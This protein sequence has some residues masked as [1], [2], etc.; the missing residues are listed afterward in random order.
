MRKTLIYAFILA[1]AMMLFEQCAR[2]PGSIGGGPKDETPPVFLY[3]VPPNFTT[4]FTANRIHLHF[5]E[6]LQLK[7][8]SS[9]FYSSP[10]MTKKPE[11]LNYGKRLRV[12]FKEPLLP[13]ATYVL[14]F[15]TSITDNNEGN[16]AEGFTYV[17]S[18]GNYID[19]MTFTGRVLNAFDLKPNPKDDRV[20]TWV[21]LYDNLNDSVVYKEPPVYIARTDA[22]GFFT[23]SNIRPD[24]FMIFVLRDMGGNLI[25][26]VPNESI[27][28]S[29]TL[30]NIEPRIHHRIDS[31]FLF[32]SRNTPDS[33]KE[34]TP[35]ILH[36]DIVLFQFE[37]EPT[38]QNR[39]S[40]TRNEANLMRLAYNL[41]VDL[42]SFKIEILEHEPLE[43]WYELETSIN[44]DTINFWLTDTVLISSRIVAARLY[45]P[46]TDSLNNLVYV[47]DT[48]RFNYDPP[49]QAAPTRRR[50]RGNE[51]EQRQPK[52]IEMMNI[53]TNI[54][55]GG[56]ME[57][58]DRMSLTSSQPIGNIDITK[59]ILEEEVDTLKRPVPFRFARDS[60]NIRRTFI[61]WTLKEDTRYFLT[62]DSMAFT[63]VYG[64]NNDS[65]G[66]SFKTR[67]EAF[68]SS[69]EITFENIP[70]PLIVQILKGDKEE[71]VRQMLLTD[72]NVAEIDML[73]PDTYIIKVIYDSNGNGRWDTGNYSKKIQPERVEYFSEPEVTTHSSIK[74]ELQ[75]TL[76]GL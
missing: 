40:Y 32:T 70:C 66:F 8:V 71:L 4:G 13:N 67:D 22:H 17:F 21:M 26:D 64:V 69:I 41:P 44:R 46:R 61:D 50:D 1:T 38:R 5:D 59:I 29:D 3:S 11:V 39:L 34:M 65:T 55:S 56:T 10:P 18:T 36:T 47:N 12:D 62:I 60:T 54:R 24:T 16:V 53:T 2:I 20:A 52:P 58:T 51:D 31:L 72:G 30:I 48:L 27:A 35:E 43:N 19:S 68:Y 75:W 25:F 63:S 37:E 57:L 23:I 74:T 49:R 14:D 6:F 9:Q 42:D 33:I 45:S 73:S 15:G 76:K 7:D 28:F